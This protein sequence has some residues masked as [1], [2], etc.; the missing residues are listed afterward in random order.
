MDSVAFPGPSLRWVGREP[1]CNG[2]IWELLGR[3]GKCRI[4]TTCASHVIGVNATVGDFHPQNWLTFRTRH[5]LVDDP[6]WIRL[7]TT[8]EQIIGSKGDDY[9]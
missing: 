3:I 9:S 5:H 8:R 4:E 7:L 1:R 2:E 6:R